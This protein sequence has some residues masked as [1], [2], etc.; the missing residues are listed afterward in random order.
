MRREIKMNIKD[1]DAK[2]K[3]KLEK[4]GEV[5]STPQWDNIAGK[6]NTKKKKRVMLPWLWTVAAA[7]IAFAI[8]NFGVKN[9]F[10][11]SHDIIENPTLSLD[12]N[13]IQKEET[14]K[15]QE[16]QQEEE[17]AIQLLENKNTESNTN[18]TTHKNSFVKHSFKNN[19]SSDYPLQSSEEKLNN[20]NKDFAKQQ[21]INENKTREATRNLDDKDIKSTQAIANDS[22]QDENYNPYYSASLQ[23]QYF[24][25]NNSLPDFS[26]GVNAGIQYGNQQAGYS[27]ALNARQNISDK[28]YVEGSVGMV[29]SDNSNQVIG[30]P[31]SISHVPT[32]AIPVKNAMKRSA[33]NHISNVNT[34]YLEFSPSIGYRL[35]DFLS[36]STGPDIQHLMNYKQN[37]NQFNFYAFQTD[38]TV[39]LIPNTDWGIKAQTELD[40]SKNLK[41]GLSYRQGLNNINN[42]SS[43]QKIN[44]NYIQLQFKYAFGL[45]RD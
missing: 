24:E 9:K 20:N 22:Y 11:N 32:S 8:W 28:F 36:I 40:L 13:N 42:T 18:Q 2:I 12:Q 38:G 43:M 5:Q 21:Q 4:G 26:L 19:N 25:E 29:F 27:L 15:N 10:K 7:L 34:F 14:L 39:G 44:R 1:F 6:I 45:K 33:I 31:T 17:K 35:F 30:L 23:N 37:E 16:F 41:A 3:E